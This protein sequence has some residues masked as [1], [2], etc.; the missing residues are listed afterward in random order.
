[1]VTFINAH[2]ATY[3]VEPICAVVPIAPSTYYAHKACQADPSRLPARGERDTWLKAQIRRVWEANSQVY[4]VRKTWRQLT[5]EGVRVARC[6]VARLMREM[7]LEGAVRYRQPHF[8]V[9]RAKA[10]FPSGCESR[11]ATVAPAGSRRSG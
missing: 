1:M 5:R 2:R 4:G 7:G 6:S 3:G 9:R 8:S 11:P 10:P